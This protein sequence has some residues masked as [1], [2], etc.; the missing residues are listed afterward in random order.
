MT[1]KNE[2]LQLKEQE[3]DVR[4]NL[5]MDAAERVFA[6]K[7]FD[8][9]NMREIAK[10]AG[11]SPGTIYTYFTDQ[12]TL[13]VEASMRGAEHLIE[14]VGRVAKQQNPSVEDAA[15]AYIDTT[16]TYE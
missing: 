15:K 11:I 2:F 5:I 9:V 10:E 4:R 1:K 12:E 14:E 3:R 16:S 13:F 7:T 6:S 8:K